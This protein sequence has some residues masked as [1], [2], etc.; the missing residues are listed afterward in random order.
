MNVGE[1][2]TILDA[3]P[4]DF[5]VVVSIDRSREKQEHNIIVVNPAKWE[6]N[7]QISGVLY[8]RRKDT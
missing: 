1:L 2:K 6:H 8:D 7:R 3:Y 5:I 4:D